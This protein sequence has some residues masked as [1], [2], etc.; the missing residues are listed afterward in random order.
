MAL[1]RR[2]KSFTHAEFAAAM[3]DTKE[4]MRQLICTASL[5][6]SRADSGVN[7]RAHPS[8]RLAES[9]GRRSAISRVQMNADARTAEVDA[10]R[11]LARLFDKI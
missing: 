6:L 2:G 4:T 7:P 3:R 8:V 5:R 11:T 9:T 10:A 1:R